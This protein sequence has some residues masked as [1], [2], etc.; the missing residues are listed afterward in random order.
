MISRLIP[1]ETERVAGVLG[2]EF[3]EEASRCFRKDGAVIIENIVD[4]EVIV[5]A[6]QAFDTA[7]TQFCSEREDVKRVGG[8]RFMITVNLEP[9]FD[10]PQLFANPCLLP[11][12]SAA[13]DESFVVDA[14]GVIC[15]LP[16]ATA[17]KVHS[18]GGD[19]FQ[20]SDIDRLLP[21][22]AITVAIPLI[23]MNEVNGTTALW[24]GSHRDKSR[25]SEE[26][27]KPIVREGSCLLWDFR[28]R[29][30]GTANQGSLPRPLL[31]LTY[32]R[33]W[34]VDHKNFSEDNPK[35]K[36]LLARKAFLSGLSQQHRR[37]MARV[38]E[39]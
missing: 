13:L 16:S 32:C 26:S 37:L 6:R 36:P 5:R 28:L 23:E 18:D 35:Q 2:S 24:L 1:S 4:P 11:I 21:A 29:H 9:P 25:A 34:F 31:Y 3:I 38:H 30:G 20:R 12:L 22:T 14:F 27:T 7:Y 39:E 17:Q 15:A 33:P 10:D 8:A 19:L